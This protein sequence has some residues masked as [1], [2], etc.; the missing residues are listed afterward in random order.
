MSGNVHPNPGPIFPC[1]VCAGNVT[2][3]D[4][5]VQCCTCSKWIHLRCSQHSLSKFRTLGSSHS[6]SFPPA[7]SPLPGLLRHVYFYCAIW[8]LS[9]NPA[10]PPHPCLQTSYSPFPHFMSFSPFASLAP[11]FSPGCPS[12]PPTSTPP[13][14]LRVLQWN[15]GGLRAR[16]AELLHFRPIPLTLTVSRNPILTH[17]PLFGFLNFLLCVLIAPTPGLAFSLLMPSMLAAASSFL[18]SRAFL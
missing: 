12:T 4:K 1:S 14:S 6:W 17:L 2:W 16:S 9:A 8:P 11:L 3:G 15:A 18:S 10:L 5:S 7:P 13:D